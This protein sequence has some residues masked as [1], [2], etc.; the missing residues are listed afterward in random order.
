M[1]FDADRKIRADQDQEYEEA[2]QINRKRHKAYDGEEDDV[3]Y[4]QAIEASLHLSTPVRQK[5]LTLSN[6]NVELKFR[7]LDGTLSRMY[8]YNENELIATIA[9]DIGVDYNLPNITLQFQSNI[10]SGTLKESNI[11]NRSLLIVSKAK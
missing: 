7:L 9:L 6:P 4:Q 2:L 11:G 10:L 3:T 5:P 8:H 1:S